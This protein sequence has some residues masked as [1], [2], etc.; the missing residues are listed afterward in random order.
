MW[1]NPDTWNLDALNP[2]IRSYQIGIGEFGGRARRNT[3]A[4]WIRTTG[5]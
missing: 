1:N 4:T 2:L 3:V 5:R